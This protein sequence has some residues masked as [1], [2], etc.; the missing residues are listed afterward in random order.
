MTYYIT[1]LKDSIGNNYLGIKFPNNVLSPFL[2]E[3]KDYLGEQE[4]EKYTTEQKKRDS[5]S[6]HA[7]VINVRDYNSLSKQLGMS[8]FINSLEEVFKFRIDDLRMMGVGSAER[9]GNR[10]YFVVLKSD[11]LQAVRNKYN[12]GQHDFHITLGF[13]A[14]DV[15]GVRKNKVLEKKSNLLETIKE[16]FLNRENFEFVKKIKNYDENTDLEVIPIFLDDNSFKIKVGDFIMDILLIDKELFIV[17]KYK[18]KEN[19]KRLPLSEI[20]NILKR[21]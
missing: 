19:F 14:K 13:Y 15:F 10:A 17:S 3:L 2:N 9:S 11:K 18:D 21:D 1:Y 5:G 4:F 6:Y 20:I 12:L 16:K 8:S 7:T